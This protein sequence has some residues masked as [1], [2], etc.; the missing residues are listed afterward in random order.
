MFVLVVS[1]RVVVGARRGRRDKWLMTSM[2]CTTQQARHDI[3]YMY[4]AQAGRDEGRQGEARR[5]KAEN[6]EANQ[7]TQWHLTQFTIGL[8]HLDHNLH[9]W[10]G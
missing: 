1:V 10:A 5:G 7:D 3:A 4:V 6:R 9:H 2:T 8:P